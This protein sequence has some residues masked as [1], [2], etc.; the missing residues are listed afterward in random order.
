VVESQF[1]L[2]GEKREINAIRSASKVNL[3]TI[4]GRIKGKQYDVVRGVLE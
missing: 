2:K 3:D 1:W 4:K